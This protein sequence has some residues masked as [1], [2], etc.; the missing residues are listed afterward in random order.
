MSIRDTVIEGIREIM[1]TVDLPDVAEEALRRAQV[2]IDF[3]SKGDIEFITRLS[4]TYYGRQTL[5]QTFTPK[6]FNDSLYSQDVLDNILELLVA[7]LQNGEAGSQKVPDYWWKRINGES[8]AISYD[9]D[10]R[11]KEKINSIIA[12]NRQN[13]LSVSTAA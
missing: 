5:I 8:T 11:A 9:G 12:K 4:L 2:L 10:L 7:A 6:W 13:E 3:H 1:D